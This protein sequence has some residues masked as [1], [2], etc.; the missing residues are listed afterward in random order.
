[1]NSP[2]ASSPPRSPSCAT[3]RKPSPISSRSDM[4]ELP[5][6]V[7][8]LLGGGVESTAL[9]TRFL[10]AGRHVTSVHVHCGLIW[11][12][13]ESAFARRFCESQAGPRLAPLVE[14]RLP[15]QGFL[16]GHWAVTG[17][18]VPRAGASSAELEIPL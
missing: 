13:C 5:E 17:V 14:I 15:L 4:P 10:A 18:N 16:A 12:D 6:P 2:R 9:V 8:V 1:M 7:I 11:D 3:N